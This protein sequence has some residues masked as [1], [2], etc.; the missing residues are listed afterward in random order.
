[1]P[2]T[3][4]A[5]LLAAA[6]FLREAREQ[7]PA[8]LGVVLSAQASNEDLFA[9]SRLVSE[10]LR[11]DRVYLTGE[12]EGWSDD[13]LVSADKNPNTTGAKLIGG[14][15]LRT[16]AEL[17]RDLESGVVTALLV[18]GGAGVAGPFDKLKSLV[19]VTSHQGPLCAAAHV[20][21]P[22]ALWAEIDGTFFNRQGKVQRL[23]AAITPAGQSRP[24]WEIA[25]RL[26][27]ALGGGLDYVDA[28]DV[29]RAAC[30]KVTLMSG[31]EWGKPQMPIQLRF[32][33]SRG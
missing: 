16:A 30:E 12:G 22:L 3:W 11:V 2:S 29:F 27:R 5:A 6:R 32:A 19:V 26:A 28:Q 10:Q 15:T 20:A 14:P 21:F 13:I 1:V 9:F 31:A 23:R 33:N 18:V 25:V 8:S 4:D 24:G 7:S 17:T